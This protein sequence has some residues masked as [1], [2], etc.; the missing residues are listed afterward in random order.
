M[1]E[2]A[3]ALTDFMIT[4]LCMILCWKM[5]SFPV[6]RKSLQL[7]FMGVFACA[8]LAALFGG[9]VHGFMPTDDNGWTNFLWMAT[10]ITV[11]ISSYNLWLI[12]FEILASGPLVRWGRL[13][14]RVLLVGYIGLVLFVTQEFYI[15][16]LS[17]IPASVVLFLLL[18]MRTIRLPTR[19]NWSGLI[20]LLLTFVAAFVQQKEIGI[21]PEYF[22]HNV[23]Y[24]VLQALG[25]W[26]LYFFGSR[27]ARWNT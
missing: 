25:L 3:V 6:E 1:N 4:A 26:G 15:A 21:H 16:I 2:P 12:N 24:H 10:L 8:G 13:I 5:W 17:Y 18:L 14:A 23:L 20:G 27:A 19:F 11:G 9:I 7:N 22:N